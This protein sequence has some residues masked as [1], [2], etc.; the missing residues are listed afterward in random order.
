MAR[1][2]GDMCVFFFPWGMGKNLGLSPCVD[3]FFSMFFFH[4][5]QK[6][7]RRPSHFDSYLFNQKIHGE[8]KNTKQH[9]A[10]P[11][12]SISRLGKVGISM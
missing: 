6:N 5:P 4:V 7:G 2:L 11:V 8:I 10:P 1:F 3:V 9:G 12:P